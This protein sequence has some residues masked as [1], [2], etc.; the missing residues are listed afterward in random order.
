MHCLRLSSPESSCAY[1]QHRENIVC[2]LRVALAIIAACGFAVS[3]CAIVSYLPPRIGYSAGA[4]CLCALAVL[5]ICSVNSQRCGSIP[6][7]DDLTNADESTRISGYGQAQPKRAAQPYKSSQLARTA[8]CP[9]IIGSKPVPDEI[10]NS[11]FILLDGPD[12][13]R[14]SLVCKSWHRIASN[15]PL[16]ERL[17]IQD[18][19]SP[20]EGQ[21]SLTYDQQDIY[22]RAQILNQKIRKVI[23]RELKIPIAK[24]KCTSALLIVG[25]RVFFLKDLTCGCKLEMWDASLSTRLFS[26]PVFHSYWP[27]LKLIGNTVYFISTSDHGAV[28]VYPFEFENGGL[29]PQ[30]ELYFEAGQKWNFFRNAQ[31][32]LGDGKAMAGQKDGSIEIIDLKSEGL[33]RRDKEG[34]QIDYTSEVH[35][36]ESRE[37]DWQASFNHTQ[38]EYVTWL[39]LLTGEQEKIWMQK[40][41]AE[42]EIMQASRNIHLTIQNRKKLIGHTD[43]ITA[44]KAVGNYL[45]SSSKDGNIKQWD[46]SSYTCIQ[47]IKT[48][49]EQGASLLQVAGR[50]IFGLEGKEKK[51]ICQWDLKT[52]ECLRRIDLPGDCDSFQ[53]YGN[54]I[55]CLFYQKEKKIIEIYDLLTNERIK[56]FN[57]QGES[58][59]GS[60]VFENHRLHLLD[61][62]QLVAWDFSA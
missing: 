24:K 56:A 48:E 58:W 28:R 26:A 35:W 27:R 10:C 62:N 61:S 36:N 20:T 8:P 43:D 38:Y 51:T 50:Y 9:T 11:I 44:L 4:A 6:H 52:G 59:G 19:I 12:L 22:R 7:Q 45:F 3:I 13:A 1:F 41:E 18:I 57:Y 2:G 40:G 33:I 21:I 53:I 42:R 32:E 5:A 39:Y 29:N 54:L 14:A 23:P 60:F 17:C 31:F 25:D 30:P 37:R 55:F 46:L 15:D 34:K 16:W 47:T 49:F